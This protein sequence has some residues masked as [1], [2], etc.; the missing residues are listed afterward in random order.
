MVSI[1]A[2]SIRFHKFPAGLY[3]G[4]MTKNTKTKTICK[5]KQKGSQT[6]SEKALRQFCEQNLVRTKSCQSALTIN[7]NITSGG[8]DMKKSDASGDA[9]RNMSL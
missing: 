1:V 7:S 4:S 8:R 5:L 3:R 9:Y 6:G 2:S